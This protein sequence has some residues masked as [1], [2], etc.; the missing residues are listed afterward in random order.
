MNSALIFHW[1]RFFGLVCILFLISFESIG[2]SAYD[3]RFRLASLDTASAIACYD[4][5]LAN[6]GTVE[7]TLASYNIALFYDASAACYRSDSLLPPGF[8]FRADNVNNSIVGGGLVMN[9]GLPYEDSL[10][11]IRLGLTF[12]EEGIG[13]L[14]DTTGAW[15]PTIRVC[16]DIKLD[17]ITAP[18]TCLEI[19]FTDDSSRAALNVFPDIVQE[20]NIDNST[21]DVFLNNQFDVIPNANYSSCFVLAEDNE[22]LCGDGIDNDEDGL[23]DCLDD[24]C[25]PGNLMIITEMIECT[26]P[27]GRIIINGASEGA[28]FSID[29]GNTFGSDTIFENLPAGSFDL[30]AINNE[31][32]SCAFMSTIQFDEPDCSETGDEACSDGIDNDGDGLID[33]MDDNCFPQLLA[34]QRIQPSICPLLEDGVIEIITAGPDLDYSIDGGTT[35]QPDSIFTNLPVGSYAVIVRNIITLCENPYAQNPVVIEAGVT[36]ELP[37]EICNDGMDND[38]DGLVDCADDEC[39]GASLCLQIPDY[40]VPNII[41]PGSGQNNV[42]RIQTD[43]VLSIQSLT[44]Y[45]R[46]GNQLFLQENISSADTGHGWNGTFLN[47]TVHSGVYIYHIIFNVNGLI[48]HDTGN[49]T[50]VN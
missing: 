11:F 25:N 46:W 41:S 29:G 27:E 22:D 5:E 43:N 28:V 39:F 44:I 13:M 47:N 38:G 33:C 49:L 45:D 9:S 18:N 36:C 20:W 7:W 30:V 4:L 2:Q 34:I 10:G 17:D 6:A 14:L 8:L 23:L 24:E 26:N 21:L 16:F 48:I 40:Y 15:Y 42:F 31:V 37:Q 1:K 35:F 3:V 19:N 50:V 32:A 12:V